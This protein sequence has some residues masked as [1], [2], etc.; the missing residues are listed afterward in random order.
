MNA[1]AN[2]R[3]R[4]DLRASPYERDRRPEKHGKRVR[5]HVCPRNVLSISVVVVVVIS[6]QR[7]HDESNSDRVKVAVVRVFA[8]SSGIRRDVTGGGGTYGT[9]VWYLGGTIVYF[10]T[11]DSTAAIPNPIA[12]Y[13]DEGGIG[14]VADDTAT[15]TAYPFKAYI[16]A[17]VV[18][19]GEERRNGGRGENAPATTARPASEN[20]TSYTPNH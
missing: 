18:R 20:Y 12:V 10:A 1:N 15:A 3:G 9:N 8:R 5:A 11:T 6:G 17:L 2:G 14:N 13:P 4:E 16:N 7:T 19:E